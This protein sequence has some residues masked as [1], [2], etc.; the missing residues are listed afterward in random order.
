[1]AS[2][3]T[4]LLGVLGWAAWALPGCGMEHGHGHGGVG[5]GAPLEEAEN[6]HTHES[7]PKNESLGGSLDEDLGFDPFLV[8]APVVDGTVLQGGQSMVL[9]LKVPPSTPG[10]STSDMVLFLQRI[11]RSSETVSSWE[12]VLV[13]PQMRQETL[14]FAG[15]RI[16]IASRR[17]VGQAGVEAQGA[18]LENGDDG[19]RLQV[20]R[21]DNPRLRVRRTMSGVV[22]NSMLCALSELSLFSWESDVWRV[23]R[24]DTKSLS[25][26]IP[27]PKR[28]IGSVE[29]RWHSIS[30]AGTIVRRTWELNDG[31]FSSV[32]ADAKQ[33]SVEP[34][35]GSYVVGDHGFVVLTPD[36]SSTGIRRGTLDPEAGAGVVMVDREEDYLAAGFW[37]RSLK[38]PKDSLAGRWRVF[39]RVSPT[40]S[41][42]EQEDTE[43]LSGSVEIASDGTLKGQIGV[44]GS[45]PWMG[46][47][48]AITLV[49][50]P[51]GIVELEV[52]VA[53]QR[54]NAQQ[55]AVVAP[56]DH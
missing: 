25:L 12:T 46:V 30:L 9:V 26:G 15:E 5:H 52:P 37:W 20:L 1:M 45:A 35:S 8:S 44:E 32:P 17:G 13:G 14:T 53:L 4:C 23:V 51:G 28:Q 41:R 22:T 34:I 54:T 16:E 43:L 27:K 24:K 19:F 29:G 50:T 33:G 2:K 55:E 18:L 6:F 11:E 39:G 42:G 7:Q 48:G 36:G 10:L 40:V 56:H 38:R 47:G 21:Q 3:T 49:D 31:V